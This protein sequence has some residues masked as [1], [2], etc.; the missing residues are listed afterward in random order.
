MR[1]QQRNGGAEPQHRGHQRLGD[2]P[3]HQ[4]GIA[5]PE[6]GDGLEGA[7]HAH[8]G[9]QQA[10]QRRDRGEHADGGQ[11]L[12]HLR[13]VGDDHAFQL[14]RHK[15][16]VVEMGVVVVGGEDPAHR[17]VGVDL[18]QVLKLALDAPI[19]RR[20]PQ[21]PLRHQDQADGRDGQ[22]QVAHQAPLLDALDEARRLHQQAQQRAPGGIQGEVHHLFRLRVAQC[23]GAAAGRAVRL[24]RQLHQAV[25]LRQVVEVL[26]VRHHVEK[27]HPNGLSLVG[28]PGGLDD[29]GR[30]A[31]DLAGVGDLLHQQ[32]PERP[33]LR[34]GG[35]LGALRQRRRLGPPLRVLQGDEGVEQQRLDIIGGLAEDPEQ[36]AQ[37]ADAAVELGGEF[38]QPVL[39]GVELLLEAGLLPLQPGDVILNLSQH[40]RPLIGGGLEALLPLAAVLG[41]QVG[42]AGHP[43]VEFDQAA[44]ARLLRPSCGWA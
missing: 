44:R 3:R 25:A 34:D 41:L 17:V 18:I 21:S 26:A 16:Q 37:V 23:L 1:Q 14:P 15:V 7:D 19:D 27:A 22:N 43:F 42:L 35:H 6:Q 28:A 20:Q 9:A 10:H 33:H 31:T 24:P 5:R 4:L 36:L 39:V 12:A 29:L 30:K 13:H 38:R 40:P 32:P 8:H 2:A 11:A